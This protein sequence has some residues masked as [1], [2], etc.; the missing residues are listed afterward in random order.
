[1]CV[2]VCLC[3][4]TI[5]KCCAS[6]SFTRKV[7]Y[8]CN[9]IVVKA[10]RCPVHLAKRRRRTDTW[11][12]WML[13]FPLCLFSVCLSHL[14]AVVTGQT[15]FLSAYETSVFLYICLCMARFSSAHQP[16]TSVPPSHPSHRFSLFWKTGSTQLT[17][18][19]THKNK[20]SCLPLKIK[21]LSS[22]GESKKKRK[23]AIPYSLLRLHGDG[24]ARNN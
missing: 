4:S 9:W 17:E 22:F 8:R 12:W 7:I 15:E 16:C 24:S 20:S 5:R 13:C 14:P 11:P 2:C 23:S 18:A 21:H 3:I 1:M 6:E 10:G 19:G